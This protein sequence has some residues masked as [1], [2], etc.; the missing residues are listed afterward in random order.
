VNLTELF[1]TSADVAPLV[2]KH[3]YRLGDMEAQRYEKV[4]R[5]NKIYKQMRSNGQQQ[6][7]VSGF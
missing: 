4:R 1:K 2:S 7:M 5:E 6:V 3:A